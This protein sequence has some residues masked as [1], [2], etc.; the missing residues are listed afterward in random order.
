MS[1]ALLDTNL[2]PWQIQMRTHALE[3]IIYSHTSCTSSVHHVQMYIMHELPQRYC[4]DNLEVPLFLWLHIYYAHLAPVAFEYSE[5]RGS[6]TTT[7]I[8]LFPQLMN[9]LRFIS[10]S[11][12][13]KCNPT[14]CT[15]VHELPQFHCIDYQEFTLFT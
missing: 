13:N 14:L 1:Y 2:F 5:C 3:H 12:P 10:T 15:L 11:N 6:L 9:T 7:Y 4:G 8:M